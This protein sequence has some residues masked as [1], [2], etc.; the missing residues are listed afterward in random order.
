MPRI[1]ATLVVPVAVAIAAWVIERERSRETFAWLRT[2]PVSDAQIVASKF[3]SCLVFYLM[4][5]AGWALFFRGVGLDLTVY[6]FVS[7]WFGS[8][9]VAGF[10][11][12]CQLLFTGRLANASP[13]FVMLV[14]AWFAVRP[15][16]QSGAATAHVIRWWSDPVSH[17]WFWIACVVLLA[18]FTWL[19]YLRFHCQ[20]ANELG[21]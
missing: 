18:T 5:G 9:L 14:V 19:S 6:Q 16:E 20:E 17:A 8:L 3:I 10:A 15:I 11:L 12:L 13:S 21:G 1:R 4:G 7:V 2:L